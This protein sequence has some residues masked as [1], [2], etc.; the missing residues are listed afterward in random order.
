MKTRNR[1]W[2]ILLCWCLP[3][4]AFAQESKKE[5]QKSC[6]LKCSQASQGC[7][8]KCPKLK[9]KKGEPT[10]MVKEDGEPDPAMQCMTACGEKVAQCLRPCTA[11]CH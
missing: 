6:S 1:W 9:Q 5:C 8:S 11:K 7:M 3:T 10:P 4:L 2:L